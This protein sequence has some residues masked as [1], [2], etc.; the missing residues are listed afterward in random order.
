M[1]LAEADEEVH[2]Y[3]KETQAANRNKIQIVA[4]K[5]NYLKETE[6]KT[7]LLVEYLHA[8]RSNVDAGC[9]STQFSSKC[10]LILGTVNEQNAQNCFPSF[11]CQGDVGSA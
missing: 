9:S 1:I 11:D 3:R 2:Q 4:L 7:E 8:V 6:T 10:K 5:I